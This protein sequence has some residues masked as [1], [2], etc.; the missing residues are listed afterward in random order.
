MKEKPSP[1]FSINSLN[2]IADAQHQLA[3]LRTERDTF[4]NVVVERDGEIA[5]LRGEIDSWKMQIITLD[6]ANREFQEWVTSVL[7]N[8]CGEDAL[9][10]IKAEYA[11]LQAELSALVEVSP[12]APAYCTNNR[13]PGKRQRHAK[14]PPDQSR[15]F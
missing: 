2:I 4:Q 14:K 1:P 12:S 15:P 11:R 3:S 6:L 5:R 8:E 7:K 9:T 10:C 13:C